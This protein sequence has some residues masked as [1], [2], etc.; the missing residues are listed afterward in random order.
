[1]ELLIDYTPYCT[2]LLFFA[3]D[4]LLA[5]PLPVVRASTRAA[6]GYTGRQ[7]AIMIS[8]G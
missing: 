2:M 7:I 8:N 1:M 5:L 6:E 3:V 4:I